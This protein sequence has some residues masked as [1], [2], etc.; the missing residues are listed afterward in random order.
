MGIWG[1][2]FNWN[3]LFEADKSESV[4]SKEVINKIKEVGEAARKCLT[5]SDFHYYSQQYMNLE[6][7]VI[8]FMITKARNFNGDIQKFGAEMLAVVI[9]MDT[10][11]TLLKSVDSD[12][13]K[14]V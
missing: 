8:G 6:K 11:R 14:G 7:E 3:E 13:R 9:K 1:D 2:N 12:S 5:S 10:L 4:N